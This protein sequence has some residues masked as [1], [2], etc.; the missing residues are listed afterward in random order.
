T[1]PVHSVTYNIIV[2]GEYTDNNHLGWD[3]IAS[4]NSVAHGDLAG[5][6]KNPTSDASCSATWTAFSTAGPGVSGSDASIYRILQI[7]QNTGTTCVWDYYMRLALG[8]SQYPG[9]S[10]HGV[11]FNDVDFKTGSQDIPLPVNQIQ[12]QSIAK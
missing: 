9:S 2:A 3:V 10:L 5:P 4:D 8:A 7:T 1:T 11:K 12:P 6:T